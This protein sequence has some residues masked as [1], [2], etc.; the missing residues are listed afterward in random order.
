MTSPKLRRALQITTALFV[1]VLC[2]TIGAGIGVANWMNRDLPS[3]ASLQTIAP[4]VKTLV[5]DRNGKLVHEVFKE[6]R[7]IIPL[8]QI[9]KPMVEA[10]LAI[11]DRRFY[12]HWGIDPI[13]I[14]RALIGNIIARRAEQ[15]GSTITQQ[16]ARNLFLTHEKTLARKLKEAV[17]AIRIERTY[18]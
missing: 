13:R 11:E 18:T 16:L 6:N 3:T 12:T 14:A 5:Y 2:G 10:I 17:L 15:G 1:V 8:R 4:P 7:S 9:P